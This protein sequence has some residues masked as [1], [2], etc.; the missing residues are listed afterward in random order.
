MNIDDF[1]GFRGDSWGTRA[2]EWLRKNAKRIA[3]ETYG[4]QFLT[5]S[6]SKKMSNR[7]MSSIRFHLK[8]ANTP[9]SDLIITFD[10]KSYKTEEGKP[11]WKFFERGTKKHWIYPRVKKALRWE[12]G[13][14]SGIAENMTAGDPIY[15]FS[16]GH[17][18]SG[19]KA[20]KVLYW[21]TKRGT[22]KFKKALIRGLQNY[23]DSTATNFGV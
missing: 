7:Y 8:G 1:I 10:V 9:N 21:T 20:R 2:R 23:M 15:A 17:Q 14:V 11:L 18:V 4:E 5:E 19:I 16:K 6:Q 3:D 13:K 22:K 12:T